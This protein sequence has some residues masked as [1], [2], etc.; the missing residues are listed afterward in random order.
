MATRR[1]SIACVYCGGAHASAAEVRECWQRHEDSQSALPLE[2]FSPEPEPGDSFAVEYHDVDEHAEQFIGAPARPIARGP[3]SLGRNVLVSPG[4]P[5]PAEWSDAPRV[6][7]QLNDEVVAQLQSLAHQR[8]GVVLELSPEVSPEALQP[9][10]ATRPLH[11]LGP[12]FTFLADTLRHMLVSNGVD[13]RDGWSWPVLQWAVALGASQVADGQGDVVLRDG[14]RIW[15]D[16]GPM[17]FTPAIDG[18]SVLHRVTV[19]HGSL[20][21]PASNESSADLAPDQLA[22]VTHAEGAARIIAPAGS[23][24]TRVLTERA[25]HL[26]RQWN[27]PTSAVCLVAFN[28]RAQ[29]EMVERTPDLRGLQVRTLNAIALAIVN[30]TAPFHQQSRRM[31]TIDE[32]D[33][34]RLIGK[35]VAFPRKRNADPVATWLEALSLARLGLRDPVEVEKVYDGDVDGFAEVFL[36]FRQELSRANTVDYDEQIYRAIELLLTDP[37]VRAAAQRACRVLLVDEFQDLTPAHLLLVRLLA[38][39]DGAVFGVGDDD[40]TIYGYNGADPGWLIDF[41]S[42]FP[43]AGEHP[44]EVNYRCPGGIVRAADTLLRHNRRRVSKTIRAHHHEHDGFMVAPAHGDSV[45]TTVQGITTAIA[46]GVPPS[47]IAVLTRVNSLL[48]PV[49][50]AL[51]MAGVPTTGGVG[52]EFAERTAVRA[53][54]AWLRLATTSG[55][56]SVDDV[57]EALR[58]PSRSM[59]PRIAGWAAEQ[60]SAA[61]L[62][63]LAE[64]ITTERDAK[65]VLEFAADIEV[66]QQ[67]ASTRGTTSELLAAVRDQ[68]GLA[69]SIATLDLHRQGMNRAAQND[70]LT[71]LAQLATLQPDPA[72]FEGWLRRALDQTWQH[73]GVT[74]ATVHRVKGLEWPFVVVHHADADQFPHRLATDHEEERR[75]FHVAITRAARDVLVVPSDRPS[76]FIVDCSTEP[77]ARRPEPTSAAPSPKRSAPTAK[78]GDALTGD[79]Q[80]RF[81]ALRDWRRHAAGSKPAYTVFADSTLDA[82]AQANPSSLDELARIKGVGPSKLEQYGDG[83][84]RV[85]ADL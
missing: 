64:R 66:L 15:L 79:A 41:A 49:Q 26:L 56:L 23:G 76:P 73:G 84:L 27:L 28:K 30:G 42:L 32:P 38:G 75:L 24:K 7:V 8:I 11:E 21:P 61:G 72:K 70:D 19:E 40:Q 51:H 43:G 2:P 47:D 80:Q 39:P 37:V 5:A 10:R 3:A 22:A 31:A 74:L 34:R 29:E 63:R 59:H 68:M 17:R 36:R 20:R 16:G 77:S 1:P 35:M 55:S 58:R 44:L 82:I 13:T 71:A 83:V 9:G 25:R 69:K 48:V 50:V 4:Q 6:S 12:R 62:R 14:T 18:V 81:Q 46:A 33:V 57:G 85:L 45:D 53:A 78:P 60:T 54:L 67:R 52:R 65:S